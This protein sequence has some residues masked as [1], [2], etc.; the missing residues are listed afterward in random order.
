MSL[1]C[2]ML[3]RRYEYCHMVLLL[4]TCIQSHDHTPA[5]P[6]THVIVQSSLLSSIAVLLSSNK[7]CYTRSFIQIQCTSWNSVMQKW[8]KCTCQALKL[9]CRFFTVPYNWKR[10]ID[11]MSITSSALINILKKYLSSHSRFWLNYTFILY[12]SQGVLLK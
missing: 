10:N 6:V 4:G 8:N 2:D 12:Q 5:F 9:D 11:S 3:L 1:W 7:P